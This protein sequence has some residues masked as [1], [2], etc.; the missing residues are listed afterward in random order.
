MIGDVSSLKHLATIIPG[1][2]LD[3]LQRV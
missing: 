3:I 2:M 1:V